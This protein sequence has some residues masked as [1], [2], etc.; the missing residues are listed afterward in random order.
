MTWQQGLISGG[1]MS[2]LIAILA[3]IVQY[4]ISMA[5]TPHYFEN[6][7]AYTVAAGSMSKEAAQAYF[8]LNSYMV[9]AAFGSLAMGI[10]TAAIVSLFLKT[11]KK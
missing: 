2:V 5:I 1:I 7:I 9:Q 3:P 10:V 8:N 6:V 4:I 11:K